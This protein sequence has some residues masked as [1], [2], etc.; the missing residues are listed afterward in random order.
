VSDLVNQLRSAAWAG[1]A[2]CPVCDEAAD[3]IERLRQRVRDLVATCDHYAGT[4]CAEIRWEQER[5]ELRGLLREAAED[6]HTNAHLKESYQDWSD[7]WQR[8]DA[9]LGVHPGEPFTVTEHAGKVNTV[10]PCDCRTETHRA[11]CIHSSREGG[12]TVQP[13]PVRTP[14]GLCT[15]DDSSWCT[16]ECRPKP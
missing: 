10:Q 14:S 16:D 4:P 2:P 5:D 12:D 6:W 7:I 13:A 1:P 8:I 11:D 9:A 15:H 3:E